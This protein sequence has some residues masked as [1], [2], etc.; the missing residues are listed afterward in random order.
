M[1]PAR[2]FGP[3]L[4]I[5]DFS[6]Y[7]V[8]AIGPVMGMV[9]AVA[10]AYVLRGPGGRDPVAEAAA[11]GAGIRSIFDPVPTAI[12]VPVRRTKP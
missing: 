6:N 3:E 1:N 10:I 4:V 7:W 5:H 12:D 9:V 11:Q 8:Y 2:S